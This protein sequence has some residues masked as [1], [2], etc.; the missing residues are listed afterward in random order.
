MKNKRFAGKWLLTAAVMLWCLAIG[1]G[2]V[3]AEEVYTPYP[4]SS[5]AEAITA[6]RNNYGLQIS[7]EITS[8]D[9]YMDYF[10]IWRK[11]VVPE[12]GY[13]ISSVIQNSNW[14]CQFRMTYPNNQELKL[15]TSFSPDL[16]RADSRLYYY[17]YV[18]QGTYLGDW[19]YC[20]GGEGK[21]YN[22]YLYFLPCSKGIAITPKVSADKTSVTLTLSSPEQEFVS[23]EYCEGYSD[24]QNESLSKWES[25]E[26]RT[27]TLSNN[28]KYTIRAKWSDEVSGWSDL[29][30]S[31]TIDLTEITAAP[32]ASSSISAKLAAAAK[33]KITWKKVSGA[34][35]YDV[36]RKE[37]SGAF[38]ILKKA[39]KALSYIDKT[40][41]AGK[42][43]TY[44]IVAVNQNG[45]SGKA[46]KTASVTAPGVVTNVKAVKKNSTSVTVKWGKAAGASGYQVSVSTSKK[47]AG[48]LYTV[49][50][51]ATLKKIIKPTRGKQYYYMVRAFQK[52]GS[53]KYYGKWS[54]AAAFT[55]PGTPGNAKKQNTSQKDAQQTDARTGGTQKALWFM[56]YVKISQVPGGNYSHKGTLNFDVVG[57]KGNSNIKAPFD[58]KIVK[59]YKGYNTGNTVVVQSDNKVQYADG[60]VDYMSMAFA[61][62]NNISDLSVGK[63]LTQGQVFYQTGDYGK[64]KGVHS[65][66]TCIKGKFK[67]NLWKKKSAQ[68][69][70]YCPD[71]IHP[72]K[73]LFLGN[74]KVINAKGLS[75]KK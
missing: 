27:L 54:G 22:M 6:I 43:Y 49:N 47:K 16:F 57:Y 29:P 63:H 58:C 38:K 30:M 48:T 24:P 67:N 23:Y 66:V 44:R 25:I 46:G 21:N 15:H 39:V 17:H 52:V 55:L 10:D 9:N 33:A 12:R 5:P 19:H 71:Q 11:T 64:A 73:A 18:D 50:G 74:A 37:G 59:I 1:A 75:F 56:D 34:V 3:S 7:R 42:K 28:G 72:V 60:T 45:A 2:S 32:E 31:R 26:G 62:D 13:I 4:I 40:L 35:S 53:S 51:A 20:D 8:N 41:K 61:H 36:Y 68:G 65:H 69:N 70:S 14:V